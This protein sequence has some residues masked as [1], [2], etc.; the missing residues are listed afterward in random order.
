MQDR[1]IGRYGTAPALWRPPTGG[2]AVIERRREG[3]P[4]AE[5]G[6]RSRSGL[7]DELPTLA[8]RRRRSNKLRRYRGTIAGFRRRT[9]AR[10]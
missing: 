10:K 8:G 6:L 2:R 4:D 3:P 1:I 9:L 5:S 7:F